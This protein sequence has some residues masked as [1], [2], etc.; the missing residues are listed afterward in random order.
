MSGIS[1]LSQHGSMNQLSTLESAK[2]EFNVVVTHVTP[3]RMSHRK[4][5]SP[6]LHAVPLSQNKVKIRCVRRSATA[7]TVF[8]QQRRVKVR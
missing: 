2:F 6:R 8:P 5:N 3:P 7:L 1:S 4:N